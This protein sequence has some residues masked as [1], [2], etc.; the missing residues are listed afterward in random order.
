LSQ[1]LFNDELVF[2]PKDIDPGTGV[3]GVDY[4]TRIKDVVDRLN[5]RR[6]DLESSVADLLRRGVNK[7]SKKPV[8]SP[9]FPARRLRSKEGLKSETS[10]VA[11]DDEIDLSWK[12]GGRHYPTKCSS[13]GPEFQVDSLPK[14]GVYTKEECQARY[15]LQR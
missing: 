7:L 13:V 10:S 9:K 2:V 3:K 11:D 4:Y 6:N 8:L 5:E 15:V 1:Q 12:R 14:A